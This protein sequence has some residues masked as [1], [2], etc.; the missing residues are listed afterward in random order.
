[1]WKVVEKVSYDN[2][3]WVKV[4]NTKGK[5][6]L[7]YKNGE[8][9]LAAFSF[10]DLTPDVVA[11]MISSKDLTA[12][13]E[14]ICTHTQLKVLKLVNAPPSTLYELISQQNLRDSPAIAIPES[15]G[16]LIRMY[17]I[18]RATNSV[19]CQKVLEN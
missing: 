10:K 11:F 5:Q 15:I 1:M 6:Y 2:N 16:N 13:P 14:E 18:Y 9:V 12:S 3:I 4:P 8:T 7:L 19:T 17:C